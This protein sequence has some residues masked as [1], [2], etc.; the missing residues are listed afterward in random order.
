MNDVPSPPTVQR[1]RFRL[2]LPLFLTLLLVVALV[3]VVNQ[4]LYATQLTLM[5]EKQGLIEAVAA[6]RPRAA[7]VNGPQVV[8]DWASAN[9]MV[10]IPEASAAFPIAAAPAPVFDDPVPYLELRTVW[11]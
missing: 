2:A 9:G 10:P 5:G 3:G 8:A 7:L 11:R 4:R 6:A 1:Q